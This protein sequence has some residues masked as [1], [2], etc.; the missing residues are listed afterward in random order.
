MTSPI[1]QPVRLSNDFPCDSALNYVN[2]D[3][4]PRIHKDISALQGQL[5][6]M[7]Q[8][9]ARIQ[10]DRDSLLTIAARYKALTSPIRLLP[11]EI[12]STI[13]HYACFSFD[14]KHNRPSCRML[15]VEG[16]HWAI[17]RVSRHWRETIIS[18][19]SIWAKLLLEVPFY[20]TIIKP[21]NVA[22]KA[23]D[24]ALE[25]SLQH[26]IDAVF[27]LN[28]Q[29][30]DEGQS[31][32]SHELESHI[33]SRLCTESTRWRRIMIILGMVGEA[34][35]RAL[36]AAT[37]SAGFPQLIELRFENACNTIAFVDF[38][39]SPPVP[40]LRHVTL[41]DSTLR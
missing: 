27:Q 9:I 29:V 23:L 40:N 26:P 33:V 17:S 20:A 16:A 36:F 13:F 28:G 32:E 38:S 14:G 4:L 35:I 15:D 2:M 6:G 37:A 41:I 11:P 19:P 30:P 24:L 21:P 12:L 25:R 34:D 39:E 18:C 3:I 1:L 8:I 10:R 5:E 22:Q 31:P 7:E